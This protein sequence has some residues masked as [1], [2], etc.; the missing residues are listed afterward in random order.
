MSGLILVSGGAGYIGSHTVLALRERGREVLVLDDLSE[1]HAAALLGAR[2]AKGSM[3][4][5]DFVRGV[6]REHRIAAVF[7]FAARCYVGESVTDPGRYYRHNVVGTM[8]LLDAMVETGVKRF[9]LSSTCATYGEPD[10]I[11]ITEDVPQRP[12]NPYGV[13]KLA[14]EPSEALLLA[15]RAHHI[16]RWEVPRSSYPEGRGG[17][18]RWRIGLHD[19][20]ANIAA[21]ILRDAGYDAATIERV[22]FLIHKKNL[23]SDSEVQTL[24]DALCLVFLETQFDELAGR[25]AEPKMNEII[26]K[27]W[28][29]MSPAGQERAVTL[30]SPG[31]LAVLQA[32]LADA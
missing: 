23:S 10:R 3:L 6:F 20:H 1:G 29:K 9:V 18:L 8:N 24:E 16:R 19:F 27:T 31:Q 32:A 7:H 15:A 17:Y 2:I 12:I 25:L 30:V 4:D 5:R 14:G 21:E 26:R 28:R 22:I 13:T 11:P